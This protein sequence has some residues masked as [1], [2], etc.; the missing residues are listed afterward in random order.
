MT[1]F[2]ATGQ[3]PNGTLDP[4]AEV[5]DAQRRCQ[6]IFPRLHPHQQLLLVPGLFGCDPVKDSK[7]ICPWNHWNVSLPGTVARRLALQDA[8]LAAKLAGYWKWALSEPKIAGFNPYH[9][10]NEMCTL[11]TS[12]CQKLIAE[13]SDEQLGA[14]SFP[15]VVK[16]LRK[17]GRYHNHEYY[18]DLYPYYFPAMHDTLSDS[19]ATQYLFPGRQK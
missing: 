12:A 3:K 11:S 4:L 13:H 10:D 7:E 5:R 18:I 19:K 2:A 17:M 15:L 9:W 8:D 14:V 6:T 1:A 16:Q